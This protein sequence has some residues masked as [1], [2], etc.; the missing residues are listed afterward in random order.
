MPDATPGR[1]DSTG[2]RETNWYPRALGQQMY[3]L[4]KELYPMLPEDHRRGRRRTLDILGR[5]LPLERHEVASG[6]K[7]FDWTVPEEWNIRDAL[8]DASGHSG[9]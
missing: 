2:R 1:P 7:L 4:C 5:F 8:A 3:E 6:T 9:G